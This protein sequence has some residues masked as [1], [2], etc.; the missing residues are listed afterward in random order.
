MKPSIIVIG[1]SAGALEPLQEI[2]GSLPAE[3]PAAIF[4]VIHL[5]ATTPNVLD[6]VLRRPGLP[7]VLSSDVCPEYREYPRTSTAV[8][9]TAMA[10]PTMPKTLPR[11]EVVG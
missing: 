11:I 10:I 6:D 9:T 8:V 5:A 4:V 1:G 3:L 7:V 2:F